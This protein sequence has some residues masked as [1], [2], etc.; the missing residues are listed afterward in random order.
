MAKDVG[1]LAMYLMLYDYDI[2]G[3]SMGAKVAI[4]TE[5]MYGRIRSMAL[6]GLHIYDKDWTMSQKDRE[7]RV[8]SMLDDNPSNK[9]PY[10]QFADKTGG[11]RKAFAARLEGTIF[12]EFSHWDLKKIHLP[13][14][15][16][17]GTREY[18]AE[19]AAAFFPNARGVSLRGSHVTLLA[20]KNFTNE[21]LGFF[22]EID[23]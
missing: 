14:L 20:N 22:D 15:I 13:I 21:V 4:E 9:D 16:L 10:R 11:D 23:R 19:E 7:A 17:N 2:L 18:N 6:A 3:Y 12:P 8:R 1:E 5:L